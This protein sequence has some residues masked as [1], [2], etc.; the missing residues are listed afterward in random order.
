MAEDYY[1]VLGVS[2][3]ASEPEIKKAYRKLAR[4]YHP[5]VNPGNKSA[6][7]KFKQVSGA[8]EVLSDP[9]KRRLY[10]EFGEDASKIGF[11]EKKAEALR[12]YRA[13]ASRGGVGEGG[14]MPGGGADFGDL[15][16]DLFG[17]A[18]AGEGPGGFH[19]GAEEGLEQRGPTRG[20]DLRTRVQL[21]L[22]EAVSGTEKT[23]SITRPGRCPVCGG[24]GERGPVTTCPT[25]GGSGRARRNLG[26]LSF[27]GACPTCGGTGKASKPCDDC[28]GTGRVSETQRITVKIPPGVQTGSQ[29]R[30]AGQGA[31]GLRGGPPGDLY[32]ETEVLPHPLVRREG[33]DL[34]LEVPIT[35]PEAMFGSEIRVPTFSGDVTVK[36]PPG[37][38]SG[39]KM[40]LRGRGVP[41]LRGSGRGDQYLVLKVV[42]PDA[43][44]AE[45]RA[46]AE[47][48]RNSYAQDVRSDVRL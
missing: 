7:E 6:E 30:L 28:D 38:Q 26:P 47:R 35:V 19:F 34:Y 23:L 17:R 10:D 4:K 27:A 12:A 14:P 13:A 5:D 33:D 40:R 20:E 9:K 36:I 29:V 31:A 2:R 37:S 48:M 25:C 11:D 32:I 42:V 15:F 43:N 16:E 21:S 3:T 46:A 41:S 1:Q 18:G 24:T 39:K 22:S 8:F 45:A 44:N